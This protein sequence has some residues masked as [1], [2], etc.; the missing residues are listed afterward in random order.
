[1][2]QDRRETQTR[3][4]LRE[5]LSSTAR[6]FLLLGGVFP[7]QLAC[8]RRGAPSTAAYG[9][10]SIFLSEPFATGPVQFSG[11]RGVAENWFTK[12]G[13]WEHCV[14]FS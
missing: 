9:P 7:R 2:T 1:M 6:V 3:E 10:N 8:L 4:L 5:Y 14:S 13:F 12:P 11:P